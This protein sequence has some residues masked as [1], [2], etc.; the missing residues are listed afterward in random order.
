[1]ADNDEIEVLEKAF[2]QTMVD[3]DAKAAAAMIADQGLVTGPMGAMAIDPAKY[4][5]M[6]EEGQWNLTSFEMS[7]VQVVRPSD[8]V[9]IIA[10]KVHQ[11]GDM[12]GQDMDLNCVDST[13]WVKDGGDW[14]CALHT[15]TILGEMPLRN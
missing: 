5:K 7:D 1:M 14:K 6:T 4:E 11:K 8:G 12:K 15:E 3:K 13:T 2:W 9:A 10:Y